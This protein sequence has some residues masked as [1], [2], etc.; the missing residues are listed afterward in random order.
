MDIAEIER[1][2]QAG[3]KLKIRYRYPQGGSQI[4]RDVYGERTDK[5]MDVSTELDRFYTLF[6]GTTP[7]WLESDEIV[8]IAEDDEIYQEFS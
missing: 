4:R 8:E 1:R 5:L 7:I 6:R 3:E 2:L